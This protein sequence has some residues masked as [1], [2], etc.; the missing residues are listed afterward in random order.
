MPTIGTSTSNANGPRVGC[1][2]TKSPFT[3][4]GAG[5]PSVRVRGNTSVRPAGASTH[6]CS[7]T[8]A[9]ASPSSWKRRASDAGSRHGPSPSTTR[10][11][12]SAPTNAARGAPGSGCGTTAS[13]PANQRTVRQSVAGG[14]SR[15]GIERRRVVAPGWHSSSQTSQSAAAT[16]SSVGAVNP[17]GTAI[18]TG[19][20]TS[21]S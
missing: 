3:R 4:V 2:P 6:G 21:S 20:R 11:T 12:R 14:P 19:N 13:A 8:R 17:A 9:N 10:P 1:A 16:T 18:V 5:T 15:T 7:S